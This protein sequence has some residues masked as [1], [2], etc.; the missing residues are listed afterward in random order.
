[1]S[2]KTLPAASSHMASENAAPLTAYEIVAPLLPEAATVETVRSVRN[3]PVNRDVPLPLPATSPPSSQPPTEP[4]SSGRLVSLDVMRGLTVCL[5]ILVNYQIED[6]AFPY[7][8]H[9]EWTDGVSIADT[10]FPN[11]LFVMG[12]AVPLAARRLEGPVSTVAWR[13]AKRTVVL[14]LLGMF[15]SN[16]PFTDPTIAQRWRPMG[17]LQ[18]LAIVYGVCASAFVWLRPDRPNASKRNVLLF[19]VAFPLGALTLWLALTFGVRPPGCDRGEL[20]ME[21]SVESYFDS[22]LFGQEHNYQQKP[23]DP[24]GT[25]SQVTATLSCYLGL[26]IGMLVVRD[27]A[28]LRTKAGQLQRTAEWSLIAFS[29]ALLAYLFNGLIPTSKVLWTPTFVLFAGAIS[30]VELASMIYLVDT[31]DL[32]HSENRWIARPFGWLMD[33]SLAVGR[34]PLAIY[35][36]SELFAAIMMTIPVPPG[37]DGEP[38]SLW[39]ILFRYVLASWLPIYLNSLIWSLAWVLAVYIPMAI[40][41]DRR[42]WYLKL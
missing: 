35:M 5:M 29:F 11:F 31:R 37:A 17:V 16:F 15:L 19:N 41:L 14:F 4:K 8:K 24:E 21:C 40:L 6:Q 1:M 33:A 23:F 13:I 20:T 2:E 38:R 12:L 27:R 10:V 3:E 34:N 32:R 30:L 18:R 9:P 22:S 25:L 42:G 36:A 39:G 7:L 26:R 28:H